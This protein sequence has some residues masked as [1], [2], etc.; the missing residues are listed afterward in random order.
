LTLLIF[1][2]LRLK[3]VLILSWCCIFQDAVHM[4]CKL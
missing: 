3:T 2:P 1:E 4:P